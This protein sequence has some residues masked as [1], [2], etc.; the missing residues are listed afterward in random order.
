V[1]WQCCDGEKEAT[2]IL[3]KLVSVQKLSQLMQVFLQEL[4]CLI[5]ALMVDLA[6]AVWQ[7][8]TLQMTW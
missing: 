7:L 4:A 5:Q 6:L 3:W 2:L 1:T 8:M